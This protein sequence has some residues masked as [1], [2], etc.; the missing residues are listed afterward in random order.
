VSSS[1]LLT[2]RPIP[3]V[4]YRRPP[5]GINAARSYR[6]SRTQPVRS[7]P[8]MPGLLRFRALTRPLFAKTWS[9]HLPWESHIDHYI[10]GSRTSEVFMA[11]R[12]KDSRRIEVSSHP[13][14]RNRRWQQPTR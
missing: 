1:V 6:A 4:E 11:R 5:C 7:S 12:T 3:G 2:Q 13:K 14:Q 9:A 10:F 8:T